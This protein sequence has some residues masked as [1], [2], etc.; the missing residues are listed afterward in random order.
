MCKCKNDL[1]RIQK[2]KNIYIITKKKKKRYKNYFYAPCQHEQYWLQ[3]LCIISFKVF[4]YENTSNR[5]VIYVKR[6]SVYCLM[7]CVTYYM[8]MCLKN[9]LWITSIKLFT[10]T[11]CN[12]GTFGFN[13]NETCQHVCSTGNGTCDVMTG[14]CPVVWQY[15]FLRQYKCDYL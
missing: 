11:G 5:L 9:K 12:N 6:F 10:Y 8:H 4:E 13:C 3:S 2:V 1:T 14:S 7:N 15:L